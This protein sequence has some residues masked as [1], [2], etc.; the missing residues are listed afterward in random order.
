M[1]L[2]T[3]TF[4]IVFTTAIVVFGVIVGFKFYYENNKKQP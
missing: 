4:L 2:D 3:T 1:V